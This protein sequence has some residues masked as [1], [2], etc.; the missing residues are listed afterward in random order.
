M[1]RLI[2]ALFCAIIVLSVLGAVF[3]IA[4]C[5]I[6]TGHLNGLLGDNLPNGRVY[7]GGEPPYGY[8][9]TEPHKGPILPIVPENETSET[10]AP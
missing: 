1:R 4:S 7:L 5:R 3:S 6:F 2:P 8:T 9:P 10:P